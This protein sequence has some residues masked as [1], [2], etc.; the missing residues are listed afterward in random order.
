MFAIIAA[1]A[2]FIAL[3]ID[4]AKADIGI[5]GQ[6]FIT[7]GLLCLALQMAGLGA[8]V[9]ARSGRWSFRR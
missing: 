8:A 3:L 9:R 6:T 4:L 7:I 2:F 1:V 5:G